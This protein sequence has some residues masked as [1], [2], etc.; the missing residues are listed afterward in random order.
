[1]Q[2]AIHGQERKPGYNV[3]ALDI[4][5]GMRELADCGYHEPEIQMVIQYAFQRWE[6][7]EEDAAEKGAIDKDFY[8]ISFTCWRRCLAAA[9]AGAQV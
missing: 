2:S 3:D 6:R 7:G 4:S 8:G 9:M 1:M 5:A